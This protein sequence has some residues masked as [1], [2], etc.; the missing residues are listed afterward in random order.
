MS[1]KSVDRAT[2]RQFVSQASH[3]VTPEQALVRYCEM[4]NRHVGLGVWADPASPW[5]R[6]RFEQLK[7]EGQ[8]KEQQRP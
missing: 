5:W 7:N 2:E 8:G 4:M 1:V 6:R 3:G